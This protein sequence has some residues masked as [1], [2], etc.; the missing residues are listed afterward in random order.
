MQVNC[1]DFVYTAMGE[2][3]QVLYPCR[4]EAAAVDF[5]SML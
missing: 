5:H 3:I 1:A 4:K 2:L